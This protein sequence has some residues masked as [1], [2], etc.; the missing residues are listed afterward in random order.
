MKLLADILLRAQGARRHIVLPEGDDSRIA[1][2]AAM[3]VERGVADVTLLGAPDAVTARLAEAG[4]GESDRLR[5]L[6]PAVTPF[7]EELAMLFHHLRRGKGIT[8]DEAARTA[9]L[10]HVH[11]ALM[12]RAGYADGTVGG[13]VLSTAQIVRT[14]LQIIGPAPGSRLV[15]SY[16]LMMFCDR[17]DGRNHGCIF[18]DAGLV[19]D[20]DAE[21]LAQIALDSASSFTS[22]TGKVAR[23]AMLSFSTHGS[24]SHRSS[25]K[26]SEATRLV[27]Q[28]APDL[29]IDGELQFDAALLPEVAQR[30]APNSPIA[31]NANVFIFPNLDAGNIGYKI[32]QRLGGAIAIGPVLQGLAQPANDL[33]R[34]CSAE[35]VFHMIALTALQAASH[36]TTQ[37]QPVRQGAALP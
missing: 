2:G 12:V 20:P 33:S 32:A 27:R 17:A 19:I 18:S 11:A 23:V 35:D 14:A 5:I 8:P 30:K 31:G 25:E 13:A 10:P 28:R 29:L 6:D 16:F 4:S 1:Q 24:A 26:V 15:S 9:R 36:S 7:S 22:L 3:A 37:P 34:G 21:Q